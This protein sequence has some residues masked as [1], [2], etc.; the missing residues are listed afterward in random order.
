VASKT[1]LGLLQRVWG[2]GWSWLW[3][4][5]C[6]VTKWDTYSTYGASEKIR[7]DFLFPSVCLMLQSFPPFKCTD[8]V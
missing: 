1:A 2:V 8:F 4:A 5:I 6:R 3:H 7:G